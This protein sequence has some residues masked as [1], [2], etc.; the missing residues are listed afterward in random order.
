M[1]SR[2]GTL[3]VLVSDNGPQYASEEFARFA[4][5]WQFKHVTSSLS[6]PRSKGRAEKCC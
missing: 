6:C 5:D 4:A 3:D 1:F 2:Y